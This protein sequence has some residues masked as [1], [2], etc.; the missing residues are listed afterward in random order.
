[1]IKGTRT[2][3]ALCALDGAACDAAGGWTSKVAQD[4]IEAGGTVT[5]QHAAAVLPAIVARS[6]AG[7]CAS[8]AKVCKG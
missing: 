8:A 1:V 4:L 7:A 5:P 3:C 2:L 6:N